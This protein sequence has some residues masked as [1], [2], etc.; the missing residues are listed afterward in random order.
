VLTADG[1]LRVGHFSG[2]SRFVGFQREAVLDDAEFRG[3][4]GGG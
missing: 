2:P 4:I 1:F 3:G